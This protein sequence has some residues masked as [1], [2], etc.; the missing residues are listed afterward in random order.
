MMTYIVQ[1]NEENE[2]CKMKRR[3]NVILSLALVVA[4]LCTCIGT[5]SFAST[6]DVKDKYVQDGL[7][8][9]FDGVENTESGH[10]ADATVWSDLVGENDLTVA[11]EKSPFFTEKG[12]YAYNKRSTFNDNIKNVVNGQAFTIELLI[13]DFKASHEF[14]ENNQYSP[15]INCSNDNISVYYDKNHQGIIFKAAD[16]GNDRAKFKVSLADIKENSETGNLLSIVYEVG[17]PTMLY[18]NGS[19]VATGGANVS[20]VLGINDL[21]IGQDSWGKRAEIEYRSIRFYNRALSDTEIISNASAD[22]VYFPPVDEK[23]VTPAQPKTNIVGDIAV[24]REVNSKAELEA[25]VKAKKSPAAVILH[26]DKSLN[27]VNDKGNKITTFAEAVEAFDYKIFPVFYVDDE[28]TVNALRTQLKKINFYDL[29]IMSDDAELVKYAREKMTQVRGIIDYTKTYTK[30]LTDAQVTEIRKETMKNN[31]M[32]AMLSAKVCTKDA[33]QKLYDGR[34]PV[35][36]VLEDK[37]NVIDKYETILSG[38]TGVV[39]DETDVIFDIVCE[40]LAEN[41]LTRNTLNVGHKGMPSAALENTI[42]G[43]K[44]AIEAGADV[45]EIDIYMSKDGKLVVCHSNTTGAVC[46]KDLDIS[47]STWEELKALKVVRNEGE[48]EGIYTPDRLYTLDEFFEE[49]K[50]TDVDFFI[51]FKGGGEA[52]VKAARDMVNAYDLYD[53]C[54]TITFTESTMEYIRKLWPEMTIGYLTYSIDVPEGNENSVMATV[55][56]VIGRYNASYSPTIYKMGALNGLRAAQ[57]RGILMSGWTYE[58][59][60]TYLVSYFN[61]ASAITGDDASAM[62]TWPR[63]I[64]LNNSANLTIKVGEKLA[65][66]VDEFLYG[67]S[68]KVADNLSY[69]ILDGNDSGSI[70]GNELS[71]KKSG[72]VTLIIGYEHQITTINTP[73]LYS[74]PITITVTN[75]DGTIDVEDPDAKP[76]ESVDGAGDKDKESGETKTGDLLGKYVPVFIIV[77][78]SAAGV[79]IYSV[80]RKRRA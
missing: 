67:G 63:F 15:L 23:I 36:A 26:V 18:W 64:K 62:T 5:E 51:E 35:W 69:V 14:E 34:I 78:I 72:K 66:D 6:V 44:A 68:N 56:K 77:M 19:K 76:G 71:F 27:V 32:I 21:F 43:A 47:Q 70:K 55:M 9:L 58:N 12:F 16:S 11:T 50:N 37:S 10:N 53:R 7:V 61:G 74:E 29:F 45:L 42:N 59:Q 54:H 57:L 3:Y 25:V 41:T 1:R 30:E 2:R 75:A 80:A 60:S 49:F 48:E 46:D 13:G 28:A 65:L 38:V 24:V 20:K 22:E 79:I 31:G 17:K 39:T 52:I 73:V 8:S 33:V 40:K 4:F